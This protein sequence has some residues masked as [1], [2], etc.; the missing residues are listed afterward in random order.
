MIKL[1]VTD[2]DGT[3]LRPGQGEL[4]PDFLPL[5]EKVKQKGI[6]Y[7]PASGRQ[8]HSIHKLFKNLT[9]D[10]YCLC[11]NGSQIYYKNKLIEAVP[12]EEEHVRG[13]LRDGKLYKQAAALVSGTKTHYIER[14]NE[15]FRYRMSNF[16][17]NV[18]EEVEDVLNIQVEITKM[19]YY[20]PDGSEKMSDFFMERWK[21]KVS[22]A[23]SGPYWI[24]F[25]HKD[26]S[27]GAALEKLQEALGIAPDETMVFGDSDNDITMLRHAKYSYAMSNARDSVK[28]V[29]AYETENELIQ[30]RQLV[31]GEIL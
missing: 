14:G 23:I 4:E 29:C 1:V 10:S 9:Q 13:I 12:M 2:I 27:K 28:A 24:D 22:V 3:A 8:I 16:L 11:E 19:A 18:V 15:K 21:D 6:I 17:G 20:D 30:L 25:N 31:K 5:V 26:I 7:C